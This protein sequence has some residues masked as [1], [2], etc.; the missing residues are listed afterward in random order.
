MEDDIVLSETQTTAQG[1]TQKID[2]E[3]AE[4]YENADGTLPDMQ[5]FEKRK[6]GR[7]IRAFVT[8]VISL[9]FLGGVAWYGY[10][11]YFHTTGSFVENDVIL[12]VGGEEQVGFGEEVRYRVR[13]KNAQEVSLDNSVLEVRYPAGFVFESASKEPDSDTNNRWTLGPLQKEDGE[14]I[15]IIGR[16]YGD[17]GERQSFR[18][19][20]NYTP[21]NFSSIF[22]KVATQET[23]IANAPVSVSFSGP[24]HV[25][26]GV[27]TSFTIDVTP[28]DT[29]KVSLLP[30]HLELVFE[31]GVAFVTQKKV[32]EGDAVHDPIWMFDSLTETQQ[33][34]ITGAFAG[35]EGTITPHVLLRGWLDGQ[36]ESDA[37]TIVDVQQELAIEAEQLSVSLIA[38]GSSQDITVQPGENLNATVVVKNN[39][40]ETL[41]NVRVRLLFDAPSSHGRSIMDWASLEDTSDGNI[42]GEQL[43]DTVRR[44]QITWNSKNISDLRELK[45]GAQV[46]ID[47]ML[48][49]KSGE[50]ITL[51]EY[52][53][54][55][56]TLAGDAQYTLGGNEETST[57]IPLT[58]TLNSDTTFEVRD[59]VDADTH[60]ITWLLGN[61]FHELKDIEAQV[62]LYGDVHVDEQSAVVPAGQ[63]SYDEAGKHL[64]W[65]VDTMPLSLEVLALQFPVTVQQKNPSQTQLTSKVRVTAMDAVTGK[66]L[67]L[68]GDEVG[69]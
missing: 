60:K 64:T 6:S 52:G 28:G 2:R 17:V 12:S 8:L 55:D 33:F 38:N 36:S 58:L 7:I 15:D 48:P 22:Q 14:Y 46:T 20:L 31:P 30:P 53:T 23:T 68:I 49:I 51:A 44:G 43:S 42:L 50:D 67:L 9:S 37:Y 18:V 34:T 5:T 10:T 1:Q 26:Q 24:K 3:L 63:I 19:F 54:Y 21:S 25:S 62:D 57:G 41:S 32:P 39:T 4:I 59:E 61:S 65:K 29:E 45:P 27:A 69:L 16:L 40:Q 66:Q 11:Q 13:F 47:V 35:G 56:I